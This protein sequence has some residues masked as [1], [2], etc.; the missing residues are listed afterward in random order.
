MNSQSGF[1]FGL[2]SDAVKTDK[3]VGYFIKPNL[4]GGM[5]KTMLPATI[6]GTAI[7]Y[8]LNNNNLK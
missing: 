4:I 6:G 8:N 1:A 5:F 7:K 2:W 3:A